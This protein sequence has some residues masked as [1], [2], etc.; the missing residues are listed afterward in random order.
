[1]NKAPIAPNPI[2]GEGRKQAAGALG[3]QN[4]F[5]SERFSVLASPG[6]DP[7]SVA[8]CIFLLTFGANNLIYKSHCDL[9]GIAN[10]DV[11]GESF[12]GNQES[13]EAREEEGCS[14]EEE[15]AAAVQQSPTK[16]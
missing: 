16:L 6:R 10:F 9:F 5:P 11:K 7:E 15:V 12:D 8:E 4:I 1:V 3:G 2:P 14:E 13:C